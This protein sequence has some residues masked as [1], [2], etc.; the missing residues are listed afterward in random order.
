MSIKSYLAY[1]YEGKIGEL[2]EALKQLDHCE[3]IPAENIDLLVVV[4]DTATRSEDDTIKEKIEAITSLQ[5]LA[6]V[7]GFD[8]PIKD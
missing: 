1:P 4:T 6:L 5:T 3:I 2:Q 8:T 7:S